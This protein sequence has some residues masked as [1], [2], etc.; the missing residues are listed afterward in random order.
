MC[1]CGSHCLQLSV[2]QPNSRVVAL[3]QLKLASVFHFV[4]FSYYVITGVLLSPLSTMIVN[5]VTILKPPR[6]D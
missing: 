5:I 6:P 1:L 3:S 2:G 4:I